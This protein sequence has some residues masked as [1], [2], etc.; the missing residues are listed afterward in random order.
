MRRLVFPL[1]LVLAA[2]PYA[3]AQT[4]VYCICSESTQ[5]CGGNLDVAAFTQRTIYFSLTNPSGGTVS[6]WEARIRIEGDGNIFGEWAL[7][8][9]LNVG[10]GSDYIVGMG[11]E[12]LGANSSGLV[13]LMTMNV[14]VMSTEPVGFFIE[15][16]PGSVSFNGVPGYLDGSGNFVDCTTCATSE[17]LPAFSINLHIEDD[18]REWG[19]VKT[20]YGR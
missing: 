3:A 20:I 10:S 18:E 1:L 17:I 11:S 15:G 8:S 9:G 13:P 14:L 7:T 16:V 2:A 12:H 19:E 6:A 5:G 4:D